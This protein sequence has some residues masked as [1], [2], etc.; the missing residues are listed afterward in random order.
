M[1]NLIQCTPSG[2]KFVYIVS[3]E[4]KG[5]SLNSIPPHLFVSEK[6]YWSLNFKGL[7]FY[8]NLKI[9]AILHKMLNL[10]F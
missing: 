2:T 1:W 3:E 7:A 10:G 6:P 9:N 4:V 5:Y 8:Q